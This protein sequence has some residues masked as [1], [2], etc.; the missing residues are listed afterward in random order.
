MKVVILWGGGLGDALIIRPLLH[1]WR[2][3]GISPLLASVST[4]IPN[5]IDSLDIGA[6]SIALT[7][8]PAKALAQ[9]RRI[10][11]IDLIY[12]SPY[13]PWKTRLLAHL[14]QPKKIWISR[15][16]SKNEFI[17]DIV[18]DDSMKMGLT[19]RR[20]APYG[21]LPLFPKSAT[22]PFRTGSIIVHPGTR[23]S[24]QTRRWPIKRWID[25][26][27]S[28]QRISQSPILAIGSPSERDELEVLRL[29]IPSL[30][31]CTELNLPQLESTIAQAKL[32]ICTNSG[33]MHIAVAHQRPTVV[34]TG[35][36]ARYWR[37][38]YPHVF[39]VTSASC[40][41]ACNQHRCPIPGFNARCIRF[42]ETHEVMSSVQAAVLGKSVL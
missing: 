36:S 42:V 37:P 24:W 21:P 13:S 14:V 3:Q 17:A 10:R 38:P 22:A 12:I 16:N 20:P 15:S 40:Q 23:A 8:D 6:Q 5:L 33:V 28:V 26:L 31:I 41:I 18:C 19:K 11:P 29:A 34:I 25:L 39:N 30:E 9:L 7:P 4:H 27:H 32:A 35:S 1:A 2:K